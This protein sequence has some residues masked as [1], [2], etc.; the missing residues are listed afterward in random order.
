MGPAC[1]CVINMSVHS[2]TQTSEIYIQ[3]LSSSLEAD[4]GDKN[5]VFAVGQKDDS[6][7]SLFALCLCVCLSFFVFLDRRHETCWWSQVPGSPPGSK[8]S[9]SGVTG[10]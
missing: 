3:R 8:N 7:S 5:R 9:I 10:L 2:D 1:G 4:R 6:T